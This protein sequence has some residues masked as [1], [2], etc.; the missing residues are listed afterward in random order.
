MVG[1]VGG[2]MT[3]KTLGGLI[4][5]AEGSLPRVETQAIVAMMQQRQHGGQA[6][7]DPLA[8]GRHWK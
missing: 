6:A 4:G 1:G 8:F 7:P 3:G 2:A 5:P